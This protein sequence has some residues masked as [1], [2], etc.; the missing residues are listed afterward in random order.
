MTLNVFGS[1]SPAWTAIFRF[2]QNDSPGPFRPFVMFINIVD[3]NERSINNPG[4]SRPFSGA[5]AALAMPLRTLV[6][7]RGCGEHNQTVAIFHLRVSESAVWPDHARALA[8][9]KSRR[10]PVQ[11]GHPVFIRNHR[12]NTL[13][14]FRHSVS[15]NKLYSWRHA[16]VRIPLQTDDHSGRRNTHACFRRWRDRNDWVTDLP[17]H[18]ESFLPPRL[19]F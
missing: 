17:S 5:F 10:E 8:E 11:R 7:R 15:F 14:L 19:S 1:V 3:I 16:R 13:N 6:F 12:N 4:H 9:A 18:V 2:R